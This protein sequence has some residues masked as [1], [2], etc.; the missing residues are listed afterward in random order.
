MK[1]IKGVNFATFA[2]RGVLAAPEARESLDKMLYDLAADFVIL[3]P[4]A[5]Q[6]TAQSTEIDFFRCSHF[7]G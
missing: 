3:T 4:A 1:F 6:A 7:F 2:R 5:V